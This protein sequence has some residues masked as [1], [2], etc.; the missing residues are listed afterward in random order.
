M[1]REKE[2]K[3]VPAFPPFS[4]NF[5]NIYHQTRNCLVKDPERSLHIIVIF[6]KAVCDTTLF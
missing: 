3:L 5:Q 6:T 1:L 2:E 4:A